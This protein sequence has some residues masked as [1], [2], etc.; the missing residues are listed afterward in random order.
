M[1]APFTSESLQKND[2]AVA[3][4]NELFDFKTQHTNFVFDFG[5]SA[6]DGFDAT[7]SNGDSPPTNDLIYHLKRFG[8][9]ELR[10]NQ[11]LVVEALLAKKDCLAVMPTGEGKSLC[12]QLPAVMDSGVTVVICPLISLMIDQVFDLKNLGVIY[13]KLLYVT[14]ERLVNALEDTCGNNR[15]K[16]M[17]KALYQ[18]KKLCRFVV[19]EAHCAPQWGHEFRSHYLKLCLLKSLFPTVGIVALTATATPQ[20]R[21]EIKNLLNLRNPFVYFNFLYSIWLLRENLKFSV[22][23]KT[24]KNQAIA[25]IVHK[26]KE[27]FAQQCGIIYCF[28]RDDCMFVAALLVAEGILADYY[29]SKLTDLEKNQSYSNWMS[30]VSLV[31]CATLSF[32]MGIDKRNVRFV[33]HLTMPKSI[34]GYYQECGRAGR[35]GKLSHCFLYYRYNDDYYIRQ[36]V[37]SI[38]LYFFS[39]HF[40]LQV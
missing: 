36:M 26:L 33:I 20:T 10:G 5:E 22:L 25:D 11:P 9:S 30:G 4:L 18:R 19:D 6:T 16:N 13:I 39:F 27:D 29:H 31:M 7:F 8:I 35:D 21:V 14:P 15:L 28:S 12:F 37:E 34:E 2:V 32:G 1:L 17:L 24:S 40:G 38:I 23:H 3:L